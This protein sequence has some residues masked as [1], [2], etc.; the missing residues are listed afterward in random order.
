MD[1]RRYTLRYGPASQ[2]WQ[3]RAGG[4]AAAA[5]L[6]E[7]VVGGGAVAKGE[8]AFDHLDQMGSAGTML[9]HAAQAVSN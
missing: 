7:D 8:E 9:Q 6:V 5:Q 4:R 1:A 3:P 2:S